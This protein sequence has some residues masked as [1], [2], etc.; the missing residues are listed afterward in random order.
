MTS[1]GLKPP[2]RRAPVMDD[3]GGLAYHKRQ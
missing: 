2:K 3:G 1:G